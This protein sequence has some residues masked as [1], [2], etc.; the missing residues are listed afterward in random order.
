MA[1]SPAWSGASATVLCLRGHSQWLPAGSPAGVGQPPDC[2]R[3]ASLGCTA[4][5]AALSAGGGGSV[6]AGRREG[7]LQAEGLSTPP[8]PLPHHSRPAGPSNWLRP[9]WAGCGVSIILGRAGMWKPDP[10]L[11]GGGH[12]LHG[13]EG[14]GWTADLQAGRQLGRGLP[15]AAGSRPPTASSPPPAFNRRT[16]S[17]A[18]QT[19]ESESTGSDEPGRARRR[20]P[21]SGATGRPPY[22]PRFEAGKRA[23]GQPPRSQSTHQTHKECDRQAI[24]IGCLLPPGG[25]SHSALETCPLPGELR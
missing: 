14:V 6:G 21:R 18:S 24:S 20:P 10:G 23:R 25:P 17:K 2:A 9:E 5:P 16:R 12:T 8:T 1:V 19:P 22:N 7:P 3:A 13:S 4:S 11:W 15:T